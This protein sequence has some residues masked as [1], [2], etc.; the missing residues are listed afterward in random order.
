MKF[1]KGSNCTL[2]ELKQGLL[3]LF[4]FY[5]NCSNCTLVE[6]KLNHQTDRVRTSGSSNCTLVELK[7]IKESLFCKI[8]LF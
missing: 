8:T 3:L 6:L 2:V 7:R 5:N 1:N 4:L